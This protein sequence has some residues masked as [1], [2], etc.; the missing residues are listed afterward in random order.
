MGKYQCYWKKEEKKKKKVNDN[1]KVIQGKRV[2]FKKVT[3]QIKNR[4]FEMKIKSSTNQCV[5]YKRIWVKNMIVYHILSIRK[6]SLLVFHCY[7]HY[8]KN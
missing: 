7:L 4:L 8:I 5:T 2:M 1:W 6:G 3:N